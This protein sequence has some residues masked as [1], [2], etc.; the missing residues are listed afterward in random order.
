MDAIVGRRRP[1]R[2]GQGGRAADRRN[3][4]T[5]AS[6]TPPGRRT[7]FDY[8]KQAYL[9][10]SRQATDLVDK[11]DVIDEATARAPSSSPRPI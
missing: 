4:A 9:L 3:A 10:A 7:R 8:L 5:A 11:A 6:A 2:L 1:P